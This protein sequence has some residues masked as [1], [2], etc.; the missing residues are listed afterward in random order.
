MPAGVY[1]GEQIPH[2]TQA[3]VLSLFNTPNKK[4]S[5]REISR[6]VGIDDKTV[7]AIIMN[8]SIRERHAISLESTAVKKAVDGIQQRLRLKTGH[9]A[10]LATDRTIEQL[11]EGKSGRDYAWTAGVMI[12]K[13]DRM[14][15]GPANS[16][17]SFNVMINN[18][19][20]NDPNMRPAVEVSATSKK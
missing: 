6:Y 3:I 7:K 5:Y 11:N 4:Y 13:H 20:Q 18:V 12:D 9:A 1:T 15:N 16:S 10:E 19:N 17:F 2:S 8:D 14:V